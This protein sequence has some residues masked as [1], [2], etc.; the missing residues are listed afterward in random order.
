MKQI[1]KINCFLQHCFIWSTSI[2]FY[3]LTI[4]LCAYTSPACPYLKMSLIGVG[5]VQLIDF[6]QKLKQK[7]WAN[8]ES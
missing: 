6:I 3:C 2:T 4:F 8:K 5:D 1:T 7:A